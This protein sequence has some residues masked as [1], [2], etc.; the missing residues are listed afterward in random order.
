MPSAFLFAAKRAF[1]SIINV[2]CAVK[3]FLIV[4]IAST[5]LITVCAY[6]VCHLQFYKTILACYAHLSLAIAIDASTLCTARSAK[7]VTHI[8]KIMEDYVSRYPRFVIAIV[9]FAALLISACHVQT[10]M[11]WL[12]A[13]AF[14]FLPVSA[15]R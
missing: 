1:C 11:N 13:N 10:I 6:N 8:F 15:I 9:G 4:K 12:I 3:S 5:M 7:S 2:T 14:W